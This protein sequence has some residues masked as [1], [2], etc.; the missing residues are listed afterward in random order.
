MEEG[1][2]TEVRMTIPCV[3]TD[4]HD[5]CTGIA[6]TTRDGVR[7][8]APCATRRDNWEPNDSDLAN[9]P[10][11]EGGISY[12]EEDTANYQAALRDAGRQ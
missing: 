3:Y 9:G 7:L 11:R 2:E 4:E 12:R 8:C 1:R 5:D 10:G 6:V